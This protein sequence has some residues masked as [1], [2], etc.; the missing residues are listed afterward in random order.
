MQQLGPNQQRFRPPM[1]EEDADAEEV[2]DPDDLCR[3]EPK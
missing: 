2:L 1:K 3:G